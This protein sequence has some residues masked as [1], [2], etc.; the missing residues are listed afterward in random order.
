MKKILTIL[1]C[2]LLV[3]T[4]CTTSNV[5]S[6]IYKGQ[7]EHQELCKLPSE[8]VKGNN[9]FGVHSLKLLQEGGTN[10]A[11]SPAS[12]ELALLMSREG[13]TGETADEMAQALGM[14][15]IDN[16]DIIKYCKQL[17]SRANTD[18]MEC[19]NSVWLNENYSFKQNYIDICTKEFMADAS[20]VDFANSNTT[21]A[22]NKWASDKTHEKIQNLN[23]QPLSKE[24]VMVLVNALYFLGEWELPFEHDDTW[25]SD[26]HTPSGNKKV[27]MMHDEKHLQYY[28][29]KFQMISMPFKD[30]DFAM[31]FM[32][33]QEGSDINNLLSTLKDTDFDDLYTS[34]EKQRVKICLPKFEYDFGKS[35]VDTLNQ[36][37]IKKAFSNTAQ[38]T[39]IIEEDDDIIISDVI[40]KCYIKVDE[41]GAKAAAVTEICKDTACA[42]NEP[43]VFNADRPFI[44]AIYSKIDGTI[45]FIGIVNDPSLK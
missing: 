1:I 36:L 27:K 9:T 6:T 38:F 17:I 20:I 21:K 13:A 45:M 28:N 41:L 16:V 3:L 22:I 34:M 42:E 43:L 30:S 10:I 19:A 4:G 44:F 11:I 15:N 14:Q 5:H 23:P 40:H 35:F 33:P 8:F 32:L 29:D 25:K 26:F 12:L 18:G 31:A 2:S 7:L 24:T 37:G 39:N